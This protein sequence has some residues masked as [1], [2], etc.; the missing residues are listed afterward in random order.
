MDVSLESVF[1]WNA[2]G[3]RTRL[4]KR[5]ADPMGWLSD[6][7]SPKQVIIGELGCFKVT[8]W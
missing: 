4:W 1:S 8:F 5:E 7:H 3:T 6:T 2:S